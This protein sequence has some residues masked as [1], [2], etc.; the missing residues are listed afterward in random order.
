MPPA[1]STVTATIV[2]SLLLSGQF[3]LATTTPPSLYFGFYDDEPCYLGHTPGPCDANN[4]PA[5][6]MNPWVMNA[7]EAVVSHKRGKAGL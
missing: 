7:T 5:T 6:N 2:G 1:F 3:L 4:T